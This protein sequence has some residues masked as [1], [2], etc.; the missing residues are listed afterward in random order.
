[1]TEHTTPEDLFAKALEAAD[2]AREWKPLGGDNVDWIN[3]RAHTADVF[4]RL[5]TFYLDAARDARRTKRRIS[6]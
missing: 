4:V 6:D 1:M 5:A 3:A 2:I